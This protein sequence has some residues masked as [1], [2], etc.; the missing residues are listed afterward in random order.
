MGHHT[1][2]VWKDTV[3]GT[4]RFEARLGYIGAIQRKTGGGGDSSIIYHSRVGGVGM[5]PGD[6]SGASPK[7]GA[8]EPRVPDMGLSRLLCD[9]LPRKGPELDA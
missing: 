6:K 2:I 8:V 7:M 5:D 4:G 1:T 3:C 9:D